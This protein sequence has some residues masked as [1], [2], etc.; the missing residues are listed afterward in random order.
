[1]KFY[2][3]KRYGNFVCA[4]KDF[5][6]APQFAPIVQNS[7]LLTLFCNQQENDLNCTLENKK[8]GLFKSTYVALVFFSNESCLLPYLSTGSTHQSFEEK[9][10][11]VSRMLLPL[12]RSSYRLT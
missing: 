12:P 3:L 8:C 9:V 6:D 5:F 4:F 1:M 11:G 10:G 2:I 7:S